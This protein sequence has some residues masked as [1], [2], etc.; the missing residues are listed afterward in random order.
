MAEALSHPAEPRAA[1]RDVA[2]ASEGARTV[3]KVV[4]EGA[5]SRANLALRTPVRNGNSE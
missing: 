3:A 2:E 5:Y 1:A 4:R